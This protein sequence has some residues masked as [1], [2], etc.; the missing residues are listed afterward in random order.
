LFTSVYGGLHA[1]PFDDWDEERDRIIAQL[2]TYHIDHLAC[3]HCTGVIAVRKM[4]EAGL[5]VLRGSA[6][7]GTK[8]ELFPG[9]GDVLNLAADAQCGP[10]TYS[11]FT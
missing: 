5:P 9:N 10:M 3:N 2:G 11:L 4:V 1:A 7:N 6:R 8:T